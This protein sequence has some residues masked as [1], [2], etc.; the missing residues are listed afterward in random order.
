MGNSDERNEGHSKCPTQE[1]WVSPN[2]QGRIL[3]RRRHTYKEYRED[4]KG[5]HRHPPS[6]LRDG[7]IQARAE[8]G[9]YIRNKC[10]SE[11][12]A[13]NKVVSLIKYTNLF[14]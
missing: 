8:R 2:W 4:D 1:D 13:D 3:I 11:P 12:N 9:Y 6:L 14:L 7:T 5:Q 10:D